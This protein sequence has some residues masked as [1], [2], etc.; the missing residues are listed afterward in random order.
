MPVISLDAIWP[1]PLQE[2][3][4][5]AFRSVV[6]QVHA[7]NN[8]ISEGNFA[9]A[10]FDIRL[11]RASLVIWLERS[12]VSCAWR[13]IKRTFKRDG[14][15]RIGKLLDV[16]RFIWNFDRVNRPRIGALRMAHGPDVPVRRLF[17]DEDIAK[18]L[19]E[20]DGLR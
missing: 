14:P 11:P 3:D 9:A 8:W 5:P 15:H 20:C 6:R 12:R 1:A 16:L 19:E 17:S 18:F 4:V 2:K 7:S 10:T 13:S